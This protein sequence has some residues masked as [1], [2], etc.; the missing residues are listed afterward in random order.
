MVG[1]FLE[2]YSVMTNF[3]DEFNCQRD[4]FNHQN[5][6]VTI[7][8]KHISQDKIVS[9]YFHDDMYRSYVTKTET[10][11]NTLIVP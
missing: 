11:H 9:S 5:Q 3:S 2:A 1:W 4:E 7:V 8:G 10:H 6:Q